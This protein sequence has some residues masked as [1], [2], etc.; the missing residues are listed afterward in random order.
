[1]NNFR[2]FNLLQVDEKQGYIENGFRNY[3]NNLSARNFL[4]SEIGFP[5]DSDWVLDEV[6]VKPTIDPFVV[7]EVITGVEIPVLYCNHK[8]RYENKLSYPEKHDRNYT[9][10]L[11]G[12]VHTFVRVLGIS[13][14]FKN[15]GL[16]EETTYKTY[17]STRAGEK[18]TYKELKEYYEKHVDSAVWK[19][20]LE[21]YFK[22][23]KQKMQDKLDSGEDLSPKEIRRRH[24]ALRSEINQLYK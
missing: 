15:V 24:R 23:G 13:N 17:Y 9:Y 4:F 16:L 11:Y 6:I 20:Q 2:K 3:E 21:A 12:R 14:E 19:L 10:N 5:I 8:E 18:P 22:Q 1:M 7:K